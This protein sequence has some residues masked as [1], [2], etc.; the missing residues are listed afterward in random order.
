MKSD[1]RRTSSVTDMLRDLKWDTLQDRR[2]KARL[3]TI[4]KE[5]HK[6]TPPNIT[7][8]LARNNSA[9]PTTRQ[10]HELNYNIIRPNK[11][12]YKFSLYPRTIPKWNALSS[13]IKTAPDVATFKNLISSTEIEKKI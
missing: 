3:I 9:K 5:T 4:Y 13:T 11:D 6:F 8:H 1:Y 10:T 12:C 7:H 2:E